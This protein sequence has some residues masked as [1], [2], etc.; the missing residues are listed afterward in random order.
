MRSGNVAVANALGSGILESSAL[1]AFLPRLCRQLLGEELHLPS[2]PTWWCG[3][4][5]AREHVLAHLRELVIKPALP[6]MRLEPIFG[7]DLGEEQ[8]DQV[9]EQIK[10]RPRE[11]VGQERLPLSTSP[12]LAGDRFQARNLVLRTYLAAQGDS[13]VMMPGGLS[14]VSGAADT[15]VVSMQ[16][17]GGSKD[18]WVLSDKPVSKFSLLRPAGAHVELSRG[19]LGLPSR[20]ADNLTGWAGMRSVPRVSR[21]CCVAYLSGS[22]NPPVW[23]MCRSCRCY[24]VP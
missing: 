2:V 13:F 7:P 16:R 10:L 17:G 24:S 1:L 12:V 6:G 21:A 23:R 5:E 3:E 14:R 20:V 15:M 8:L 19:S 22:W 18:T 4:R 11:Y 9:A